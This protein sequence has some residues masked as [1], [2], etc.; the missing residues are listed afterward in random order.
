MNFSFPSAWFIAKQSA[1][2]S[3]DRQSRILL[4]K[5]KRLSSIDLN[6][7]FTVLGRGCS[8]VS[9]TGLEPVTPRSVVSSPGM[10]TIK[11]ELLLRSPYI[12][13][14]LYPLPW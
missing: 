10:M 4:G 12:I 13:N 2:A 8:L 11:N 1:R 9:S 7:D 3:K 14:G 5:R 6:V